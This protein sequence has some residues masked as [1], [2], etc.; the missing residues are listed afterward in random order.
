MSSDVTHR[1]KWS[2]VVDL[3]EE[4]RERMP[5]V[6]DMS[7]KTQL[8]VKC[9]RWFLYGRWQL[10]SSWFNSACWSGASF[11]ALLTSFSCFMSHLIC[12]HICY[13]KLWYI[14]K[15]VYWVYRAYYLHSPE[16]VASDI[17]HYL[18]L[19]CNLTLLNVRKSPLSHID[20]T[21]GPWMFNQPIILRQHIQ[22]KN[23]CW[24]DCTFGRV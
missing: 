18:S 11:S 7:T 2:P 21:S 17:F 9:E 4:V 12:H 20:F 15:R 3:Q 10:K 16:E 22:Q 1:K 13:C 19:A 23:L 5:R 14:E 24:D 6:N 8:K